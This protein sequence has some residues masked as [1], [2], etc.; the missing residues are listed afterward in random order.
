MKKLFG[1]LFVF[2]LCLCG[3]SSSKGESNIPEGMS[4]DDY[5][6]SENILDTLDSYISGDLDASE[7]HD[8]LKNL[9]SKTQSSSDHNTKMISIGCQSAAQELVRPS[10]SETDIKSE[11]D[12]IKGYLGK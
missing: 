12:N 5:K 1:I 9:C 4:E 7:A 2:C 3:C 11:R 10:P 6:V 8:K